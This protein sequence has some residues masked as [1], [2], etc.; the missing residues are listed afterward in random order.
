[1]KWRETRCSRSDSFE[2]MYVI[3]GCSHLDM[4]V[5]D[6]FRKKMYR[7]NRFLVALEF[8]ASLTISQAKKVK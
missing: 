1:M 2:F 5:S 6:E 3:F 7:I 4:D 8:L